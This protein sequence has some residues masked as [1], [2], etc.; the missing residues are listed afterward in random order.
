MTRWL[1]FP[2]QP[3]PMRS[4]HN[5][6]SLTGSLIDQEVRWETVGAFHIRRDPQDRIISKAALALRDKMHDV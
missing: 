4:T 1:I 2:R 3:A 6:D 5:C